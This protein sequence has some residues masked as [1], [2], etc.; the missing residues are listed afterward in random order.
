MR[1]PADA[2]INLVAHA[3]KIK[4]RLPLE[5][6]VENEDGIVGSIGDG[7]TQ[8][9]LKANGRIILNEDQMVDA[10]WEMPNDTDFNFDFSFD[11]EGIS[12]QIRERFSNEINRF[13]TEIESKLGPDFGQQLSDK[14]SKK[15]EMAAN[16]VEQ[17]AS[18]AAQ[19]AER[20]ATR[21]TSQAERAANQAR[22]QA[23]YTT[24]RS[25]G[26]PPGS[27]KSAAQSATPS[28][29]TEEKLE[30]LKMVEKGIITP[31]EAATLL[32]ALG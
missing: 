28:P 17:A 12:N 22:R 27:G 10:R 19:Q 20:A 29:T 14:L 8:L 16:R 23:E 21:A 6:V 2:P 26:R 7:Q 11:L 32:E 31:D 15:L 18:R 9:T 3:P 25:P 13:S 4:N 5:K 1:W 30:I 24:R